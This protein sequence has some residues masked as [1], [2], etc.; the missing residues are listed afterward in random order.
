MM[1]LSMVMEVA[2]VMAVVC[3]GVNGGDHEG[4]IL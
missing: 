1:E 4:W 2:V 3:D